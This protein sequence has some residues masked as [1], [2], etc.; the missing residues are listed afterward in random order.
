MRRK[1]LEQIARP[2]DPETERRGAYSAMEHALDMAGR[3]HF[4]PAEMRDL[5]RLFAQAYRDTMSGDEFD[6]RFRDGSYGQLE[7]LCGYGDDE[8]VDEADARCHRL[9]VQV[10]SHFFAS[11][12]QAG[13]IDPQKALAEVAKYVALPAGNT[14]EDVVGAVLD[15]LNSGRRLPLAGDQ[16][17]PDVDAALG[18]LRDKRGEPMM[19]RREDAG[20]SEAE[21]EEY[22]DQATD[23]RGR[24]MFPREVPDEDGGEPVTR[25]ARGPKAGREAMDFMMRQ[26]SRRRK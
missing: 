1:S 18:G 2:D 12:A 5:Q 14:A 6:G 13:L 24:P 20:A 15:A 25:T 23:R 10:V 8:D 4:S 16:P 21:I 7:D 19:R 26:L 9:G 11:A 17:E 22:L 3:G